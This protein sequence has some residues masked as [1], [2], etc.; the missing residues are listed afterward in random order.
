MKNDPPRHATRLQAEQEYFRNLLKEEQRLNKLA[1]ISG[2][3][4]TTLYRKFKR[5]NWKLIWDTHPEL[6][7]KR[8][9]EAAP[10][11][12]SSPPANDKPKRPDLLD[13]AIRAKLEAMKKKR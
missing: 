9:P 2:H 4:R 8:P 13:P 12:P 1:E 11:A 5:W 7:S 3:D 6:R 10:P